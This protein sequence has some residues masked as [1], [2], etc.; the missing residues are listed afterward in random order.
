MGEVRVGDWLFDEARK[1]CRVMVVSPIRHNRACY[2]VK[3]SDGAQIV[4]DGDHLWLTS[5]YA[6]RTAAVKRTDAWRE[7]RRATRPSRAKSISKKP[8][9]S[10]S[11]TRIN[12]ERVYEYTDP[13]LSGIRT[14]E[15][16][17]ATVLVGK[18]LNHSIAVAA[19]L[20]CDP[21]DLLVDPYMLGL[22]LGDGT[23]AQAAITTADQEILKA[24]GSFGYKLY[25]Y[26]AKAG[27]PTVAGRRRTRAAPAGMAPAVSW[28]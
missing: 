21:A 28:S 20:G 15:Q 3:F 11:I 7:R 2:A 27:C 19:P 26:P 5:T 9:V 4:A 10:K 25:P 8:W 22:W 16:L 24:V 17:F 13:Q 14:T 18:R 23:S 1:P 12:R 6:E